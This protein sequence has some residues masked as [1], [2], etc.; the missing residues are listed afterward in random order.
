MFAGLEEEEDEDLE[1]ETAM[2][3]YRKKG[4]VVIGGCHSYQGPYGALKVL[5][6]FE[7]DWTKF[8]AFEVLEFYKV[9]LK[10]LEFNCCDE[11]KKKSLCKKIWGALGISL[12]SAQFFLSRVKKLMLT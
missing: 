5:K 7:F 8:K 3:E 4:G 2:E 6:S 9:V 11:K 10:S 12:C 1:I